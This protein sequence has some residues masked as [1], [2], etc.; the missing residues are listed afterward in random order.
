MTDTCKYDQ[1]YTVSEVAK[2]KGITRQSVIDG[3]KRGKYPGA[4]KTVPDTVNR[5]GVW[6]I[7]K[8]VID[9]AVVTQDVVTVTRALTPADLQTM[10]EKAVGQ[11]MW[12]YE[13]RIEKRLDSHDQLLMNT[14]RAVQEKN[15]NKKKSFW[16]FWK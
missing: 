6:Q 7:P 9:G 11:K 15:E 14:L 8:N 4:Y 3:C 2:I 5:Q 16:K 12:E 13:Q 1:Y 10:I